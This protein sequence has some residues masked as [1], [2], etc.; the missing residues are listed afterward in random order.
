MATPLEDYEMFLADDVDGMGYVCSRDPDGPKICAT[1]WA[2]G[3]R[4]RTQL[5]ASKRA[6]YDAARVFLG[7]RLTAYSDIHVA[8]T[9]M[10]TR[11]CEAYEAELR[12]AYGRGACVSGS[13]P[14]LC[15]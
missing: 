8:Y 14:F 4:T 9:A 15:A 3:A 7:S 5:F 13:R 6:M 1:Y 11:F 10:L 12:A 2:P